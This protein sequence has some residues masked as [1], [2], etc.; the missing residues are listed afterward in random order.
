MPAPD[1]SALAWD[2][3]AACDD[4]G[5][6]RPCRRVMEGWNF[7]ADMFLAASSTRAGY[8]ISYD[9]PQSTPMIL[10]L[11]IP[12]VARPR[13]ELA[14]LQITSV[15][16]LVLDCGWCRAW[17]RCAPSGERPAPEAARFWGIFTFQGKHT[18]HRDGVKHSCHP[19][20]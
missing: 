17:P 8:E 16:G 2:D 3:D 11:S 4:C 7:F 10:M 9:C 18:P 15:R 13:L 12:S 19:A 6:P 1:A 5:G 14:P 20:S